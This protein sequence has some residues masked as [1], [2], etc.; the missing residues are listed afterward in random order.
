[1]ANWSLKRSTASAVEP[2]PHDSELEA[3]VRTDPPEDLSLWQRLTTVR[4]NPMNNKCTTLPIL[5][6]NNKY[7]IN[8]HLCAEVWLQCPM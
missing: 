6:L 1:M 2:Q 7:S 5:S 3:A 4:I 8:F